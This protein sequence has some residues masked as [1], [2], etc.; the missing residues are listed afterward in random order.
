MLIS[1]FKHHFSYAKTFRVCLKS[2][3]S[4][5]LILQFK[6]IEFVL[7]YSKKSL[8]SFFDGKK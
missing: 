7:F 6:F 1:F 3:R 4:D 5:R 8:Y 2:L